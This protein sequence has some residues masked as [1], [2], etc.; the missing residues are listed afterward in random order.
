MTEKSLVLRLK[1]DPLEE[2]KRY[3]IDGYDENYEFREKKELWKLAV[4]KQIKGQ[5]TSLEGCH[6]I[7]RMSETQSGQPIREEIGLY[8]RINGNG[9]G[10]WVERKDDK[11]KEVIYPKE[12]IHPLEYLLIVVRHE[13]LAK[14][15][16]PSF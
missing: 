3:S 6:R 5:V 16:T 11:N 7:Y 12:K 14:K 8:G 4:S 15:L 10:Y 13:E 1:S 2:E 9:S